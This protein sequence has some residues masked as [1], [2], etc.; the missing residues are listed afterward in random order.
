VTTQ[1]AAPVQPIAVLA[2]RFSHVH[3]DLVDSLAV[4]KDGSTYLLMLVGKSTRWLEATPLRSMDAA[5]C[6]KAYGT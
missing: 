4:A 2:K 1:S 3:L 5:V 6:A